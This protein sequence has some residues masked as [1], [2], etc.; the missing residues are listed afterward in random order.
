M[1]KDGNVYMEGNIEDFE[2]S[3][4]SLIQSFFKIQKKIP[5]LKKLQNG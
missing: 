4:D 5:N 3:T 1:L 2:K